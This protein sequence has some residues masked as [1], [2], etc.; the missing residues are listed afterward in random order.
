MKK[1]FYILDSFAVLAY[2]QAEPAGD[3]VKELLKQAQT[4]NVQ[5]FM[6]T[7]NLGEIIYIVE[8]K[9]GADI[10]A[11]TLQDILNLPIQLVDTNMERILAA[12]QI[13][14]HHA[15]SY[16]D[17]FAVSLAQELQGM[18]VTGDPEFKKVESLV[19]ILWL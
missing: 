16:A 6:S 2:L 11:D 10:A 18:L 4:G 7:I 8:R 12:A 14:A 13:K 3:K 15:V 19:D 1:Q 5:V 17:A 9:L